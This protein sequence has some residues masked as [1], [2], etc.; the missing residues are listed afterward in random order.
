MAIVALV[1]LALTVLPG[2]GTVTDTV[3]TALSMGFLATLGW[4]AY[5]THRDN[6][7]AIM[8]LTDGWRA[9]LYGSL[10]LVALL[11]AGADEMFDSGGGTLLWIAGIALAVFG[12]VS[13]VREARS[14]YA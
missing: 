9:V 10:G 8:S 5:R 11:I 13:V 1:A 6:G 7:L 12:L 3:L 14:G 2:G 4:F